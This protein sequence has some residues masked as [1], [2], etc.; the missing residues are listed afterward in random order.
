MRLYT[1]PKA[2]LIPKEATCVF[3]GIIYSVYQWQQEV[4]DGSKKT[5]EMLKRA[6]TIRVIAIK[7]DK[8]VIVKQEQ[9]HVGS[10]IDIPGGMHDH[11]DEN[12]LDAIKRELVEETGLTFRSW[13]MLS[14]V[15]VQNK[16]EQFSY[17]FLAYD[18]D[19]QVAPTLDSGE[20][21]EVQYLTLDEIKGLFT[22]PDVRFLPKDILGK[23]NSVQELVALPSLI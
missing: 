14:A 11:E 13:K 12:E 4:F 2:K 23:V 21:I 15:Q 20:K 22:S 19:T 8:I 7:D 17:I 1:P 5:F 9:P 10:F 16:I 6:D 3:T 18:F